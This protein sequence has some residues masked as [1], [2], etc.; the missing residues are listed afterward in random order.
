MNYR[1]L[2]S[3]IENSRDDIKPLTDEE[4]RL[5]EQDSPTVY[6]SPEVEAAQLAHFQDMLNKWLTWL[7]PS[8]P[9]KDD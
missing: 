9:H 8:S 7:T 5:I 1:K 3:E 6:V 2:L 4:I